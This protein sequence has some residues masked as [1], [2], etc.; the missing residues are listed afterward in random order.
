M[1]AQQG[2]L[3]TRHWRDAK[4]GS[5]VELEYWLATDQG[6]A[7]LIP[8]KQQPVFFLVLEQQAAATELLNNIRGWRMQTVAMRDFSLQAVIACYFSS[9]RSLREARDVL[10]RAGLNPLE[11]DIKPC[12]RFLMERFVRGSVRYRGELQQ[13]QNY[14]LLNTAEL[15]EDDYRPRL[16]VISLD[17]ETAMQGLSLYSIGIYAV[18]QEQVFRKVFM[19]ANEDV[20]DEVE[21]FSDARALLLRFFDWLWEY[22][23]DVIIGWNVVSFD[24]WFLQRLCQQYQLPFRLGRGDRGR[25]ATAHMRTMDDESERR[26]ITVAGRVVLDGIELLKAAF[27]QFESFA[28]NNVAKE[29]LADGKLI[30]GSDRGEKIGDLYQRDK[31]ALAIY[32]LQ[33]CKLVWDIFEKTALLDF[34]IA[35]TRMTGLPLDRVGGSVASFDFR[36]LPLLHRQGFVAPNG[37]LSDEVEAS[38]GGFVMESQPGIY[39]HVAVL[40]FKSLYPS[41]IRS[42]KIDPLGM[43]LGLQSE[44]DQAELVPGFKGAWFARQQTI[45]PELIQELW[46]LRDT[47]KAQNDNALSQAIKIIMNSFYG[48]LGSGGCRFFDSRLASSIT[49]RG[50]QIIQQ[51]AE[52]IEKQGWPVIYGDTDSVFV[53]LKNVPEPEQANK[54]AGDLEQQLNRWWQQRLQKEYG[55]ESALEIEFET[56]YQHFLMPTVR[57]SE[58]GSKKRYAGVVLKNGV[59]SLVFKG[60]ENVR[61]DWTRLA[62]EFQM[63]LYRRVFFDQPYQSFIKQ[64]VQQ[65]C[66]GEHDGDLVYRKR[67]RRKLDEYQRNIPPHVQA[68]RKA[69]AAGEK[70]RRG[71]WI[72]YVITVNGAEPLAA[73]YSQLDYQHYIDR[74]LAPV[75]DGILHF[76]DTS[77]ADI[78]DQQLG[79]FS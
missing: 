77:L 35:R 48:V 44:L 32:N 5:G 69:A 50:H 40:D 43:V 26:A 63:E 7:K 20:A 23:P 12:D 25:P 24:M 73:Q 37:H 59:P 19:V 27:Y 57:G 31:A 78:T 54:I 53:W 38:P 11:A 58:L 13:R 10:L 17:I 71:D 22:D 41:I 76:L 30:Q 8:A 62:R 34:A 1:Q 42:F 61:T 51:T 72:E 45:L 4:D 64:T 3:L 21:I 56:L 29:L 47:A 70:V 49:L 46:D 75:A 18:E 28:L 2:F 39:Q 52:F 55:I 16:R 67:L 60:L 65:V 6:P 15:T 33:D 14:S 9:Q 36:Y 74:Q 79:L 66:D 68:A